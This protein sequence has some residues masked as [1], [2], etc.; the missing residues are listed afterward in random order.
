MTSTRPDVQPLDVSG[1]IYA[2]GGFAMAAV[3][4][5]LWY[6]APGLMASP[7]WAGS[8]VPWSMLLGVLAILVP[9]LLAWLCVRNDVESASDETYEVAGH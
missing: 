2:I 6:V 4:M 5:L 9:A 1:A 3:Y 8:A 7:L